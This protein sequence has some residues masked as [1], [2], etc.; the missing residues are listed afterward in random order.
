MIHSAFQSLC[1]I[2]ILYLGISGSSSIYLWLANKVLEIRGFAQFL[3]LRFLSGKTK[4]DVNTIPS[5]E[6]RLDNLSLRGF[7]LLKTKI[8]QVQFF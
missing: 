4:I 2:Y 1:R 6:Y 7:E 3:L 8:Q 5:F